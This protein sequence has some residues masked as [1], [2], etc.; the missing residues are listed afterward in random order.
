MTERPDFNADFR[1]QIGLPPRRIDILTSI[2]GVDFAAAHAGRMEVQVGDLT[3]P[4]LGRAEL[5][6][7][8]RAT[9]REKDRLDVDLLLAA[10]DDGAGAE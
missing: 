4:M 3:V 5:I 6:A 2:D 1:D 8:K 7:N 9:G 10:P